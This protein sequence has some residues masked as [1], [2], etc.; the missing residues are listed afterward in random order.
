M[1]TWVRERTNWSCWTRTPTNIQ[2]W[3]SQL[4]SAFGASYR[5]CSFWWD[6]GHGPTH[7]WSHPRASNLSCSGPPPPPRPP[8]T[9]HKISQLHRTLI[10]ILPFPWLPTPHRHI[11]PLSVNRNEQ[12]TKTCRQRAHVY[13]YLENIH[14]I[15]NTKIPTS[16]EFALWWYCDSLIPTFSHLITSSATQDIP[17]TT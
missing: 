6:E 8:Q 14:Q 7:K 13:W 4:R 1:D 11:S 15:A 16:W 17:R 10:C 12:I 2:G 5:S 9:E 3:E